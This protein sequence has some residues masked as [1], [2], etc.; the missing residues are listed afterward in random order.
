[1][2]NF[3]FK[4]GVSLKDFCTFKIGGCAKFLFISTKTENLINVCLFAKEHNIKYKIIGLGANLL[5]DDLGYNGLIIVNK[6]DEILFRKNCVYVSSGT[7]VTNLIMKCCMRSLSGFES[8]A[9]IPSTVGG[10]VVNSLGAFETNIT[11]YVEYV[12]CYHKNDLTKKIRLSKDACKFGYRTSLFKNG[13]YI[14][15]KVKLKLFE[16]DKTLIQK[17]IKEAV[18][19]KRITQPLD[20]YS[21][22]SVFKRTNVIPAKVID[23]LSLKG[24]KIGGAEISTKHAGFIINTDNATSKDVKQLI[25]LIQ[26]KVKS[27]TNEDLTPEIEFVEY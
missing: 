7:H 11:D 22:G 21:A 3:K 13:D 20:Q 6:S 2:N 4:K 24:T 15:T 5:F 16:D 25:S 19:K 12:E 26:Q 1:M 18:E 10:A 17:R 14:I 9:G 27:A 8:L 23:E